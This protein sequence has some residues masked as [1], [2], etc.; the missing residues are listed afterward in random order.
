MPRRRR[1]RGVFFLEALCALVLIGMTLWAVSELVM[2]YDRMQEHVIAHR[3]AQLAAEGQMERF[4]SDRPPP[5]GT[6]KIDAAGDIRL[7][8][9]R[10]PGEGDW[11]GLEHVQIT[12]T[13]AS[14]HGRRVTY[15]LAAYLYF[16]PGGAAARASSQAEGSEP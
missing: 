4:R 10:H 9:E 7:R 13:V 2:T 8:I 3:R 6:S 12:A 14:R 16:E 1:I 15:R 11:K 5:E